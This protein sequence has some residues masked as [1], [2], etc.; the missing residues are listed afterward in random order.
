MALYSYHNHL[1]AYP[2]ERLWGKKFRVTDFLAEVRF[3]QIQILS[4][5]IFTQVELLLDIYK[6]ISELIYFSVLNYVFLCCMTV[7]V[8]AVRM[9]Q[10]QARVQM[11]NTTDTTFPDTGWIL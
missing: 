11:F 7:Y 5:N 2:F 9:E 8:S 6:L 1:F 10:A 3:Y 4:R